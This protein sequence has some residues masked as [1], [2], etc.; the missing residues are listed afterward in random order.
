MLPR[1]ASAVPGLHLVFPTVPLVA[2]QVQ[3]MASQLTI[4]SVV[5]DSITEKANA[6]AAA[7]A[8]LAASG[9]ITLELA[10]A[11]VPMVV[12]YK[13]HPITAEICKRVLKIRSAALPNLLSGRALVPEFLQHR[14]TPELLADEVIAL[15][16]EPQRRAA[17]A[18]GF[19]EISATM[20]APGRSPSAVAAAMVLAEAAE[21]R[22]AISPNQTV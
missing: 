7:T 16:L 13:V 11:G 15:L 1:V 6:F 18:A 12:A 2:D 4:P 19:E 5:T 17:Q 21:R 8:A 20:Q 10:L 22:A 9:T 14:C 3:A